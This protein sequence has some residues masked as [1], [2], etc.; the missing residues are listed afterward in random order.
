M[1][2]VVKNGRTFLFDEEDL[3]LVKACTWTVDKDGYVRGQKGDKV[4]DFIELSWELRTM[5]LLTI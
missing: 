1:E 3:P 2:C 5:R 4:S